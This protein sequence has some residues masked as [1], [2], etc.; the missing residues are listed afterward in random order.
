MGTT[1]TCFLRLLI[2][3]FNTMKKIFLM[4]L[5]IAATI[6]AMAVDYTAKA[7][8]TI[9]S[10]SGYYRAM[11]VQ[12]APEYGN[13]LSGAEMN[14]DDANVALYG[15]NGTKKLQVVRGAN[16][17]GVQL[18]VKTDTGVDYTF[19]VSSV[20]GSDPLYLIDIQGENHLL[21]QGASFTIYGLA[22]NSTI[23][24]RFFLGRPTP[25]APVY[26]AE[27]TTNAYGLATFSF[28]QDVEAVETEVKLYKGAVSGE[29]LALTSVNYVQANQGVIVYGAA[30]TTYHFAAGTGTSSF[31]GNELLPASAWDYAAQDGYSIYVLSGTMLYLYEGNEMKPN[32]AFLKL[33]Q[34]PISGNAPARIRMVFNSATGVENVEAEA[35][36]AEKFIENGQIFIRR[37][38]HVYDLQGQI[39]K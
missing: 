29:E 24:D 34:N 3:I 23:E 17:E 16:L 33:N 32:K 19:T 2:I 37:G 5:S 9:T 14:F 30:N 31:D 6:N 15:I 7:V 21:E 36:K 18:G 28:N 10:T 12:E 1:E 26:A 13:S 35:V 25:P 22:A 11:M 39:V 38:E 20:E 4:L 27:V 8:I